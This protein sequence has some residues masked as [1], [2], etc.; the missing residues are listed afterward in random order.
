[1]KGKGRKE[2]DSKTWER[3]PATVHRISTK[4]LRKFHPLEIE[5]VGVSSQ[6][7]RRP[8]KQLV[9]LNHKSPK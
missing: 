2:P 9:I 4:D 6:E 8:H 5:L 3:V 1:M 7:I